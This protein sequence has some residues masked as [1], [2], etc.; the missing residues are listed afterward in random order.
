MPA[1]RTILHADMDAFFASVEQLDDPALRGRPVLVGGR[2][3][4]AVVAAASYESRAFGCRS[5]MPMARALSLCP[6][7]AV[8]R[9]RFERYSELSDRFMGILGRFSPLVEALSVDEAFVDVTGSRLLHGDGPTIARAMRAMVRSELGLTV[10]VG[11]GPNKFVAKLASDMDKPDGMT[12]A[13]GCGTDGAGRRDGADPGSDP[14]ID[15]LAAWLAPLGIERMWGVG[16]KSLP[17]FHAAGIRTFGDLQRMH[18]EELRVRLGDHAIAMRERAF[19]RDDRA[20][21]TEHERKGIGH[22]TTFDEDVAEPEA[23]LEAL[24]GLAEGACRRLRASGGTTRRV[25]VK[26]RFGDFETITRSCT[27][28]DETD[29]TLAV[30]AAAKDL[31]RRWAARDF[32]PVRLIGVRLERTEPGE[33]APG[34]LFADAQDERHRTV[35]RVADAIERKF[36]KGIV[37]RG[38]AGR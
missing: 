34:S 3:P 15:P 37:G 17:G 10:S 24:H 36:G 16:P 9:P 29:G 6:H 32:A 13:P 20:V 33:E 8:V 18:A 11:I 38:R 26:I 27:L 22:E 2:S 5:A 19:G 31:F 28:A 1:P 7:A 23:V 30:L 14:A 25:T 4:R 12:V 35:D 21:E